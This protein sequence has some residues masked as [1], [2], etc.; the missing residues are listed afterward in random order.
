MQPVSW[1]LVAVAAVVMSPSSC[2]RRHSSFVSIS[3]R[4][5][6]PLSLA[7]HSLRAAISPISPLAS[8]CP[9]SL[10]PRLSSETSVLSLSS[11]SSA[12]SPPLQHQNFHFSAATPFS[13]AGQRTPETSAV[14]CVLIEIVL[15]V[16]SFPPFPAF[17]KLLILR[18]ALGRPVVA[19]PG[20]LLVGLLSA[21]RFEGLHLWVYLH[22][23]ALRKAVISGPVLCILTRS[24]S[25]SARELRQRLHRNPP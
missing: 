8:I 2:R 20:S 12:N 3:P 16:N 14:S 22:A 21:R 23:R 9:T 15:R 10:N 18:L 24:P 13:G 11:S 19:T 6:H 5:T 4:I 17:F 1:L 25:T 7:C